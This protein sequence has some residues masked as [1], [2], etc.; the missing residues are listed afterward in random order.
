MTVKAFREYYESHHRRIGEKYLS[1]YAERYVR[2]YVQPVAGMAPPDH[3]VVM[4]IW[5]RD[6]AAFHKTMQ[7]LAE[8]AIAEEIVL[9]EEKLFDRSAMVSFSVLEVESELG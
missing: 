2:R 3:D 1:G 6:E 5:F 7:R 4:E 9:D 8:P